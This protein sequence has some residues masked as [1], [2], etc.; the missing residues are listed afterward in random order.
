MSPGALL[1]HLSWGH[2]LSARKLLGSQKT[3]EAQVDQEAYEVPEA[4]RSPPP[5]ARKAP[6]MVFVVVVVAPVT[7]PVVLLATV[8]VVGMVALAALGRSWW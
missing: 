4:S 3:R 1:S 8:Q 7:A 2:Q 6:K 5:E